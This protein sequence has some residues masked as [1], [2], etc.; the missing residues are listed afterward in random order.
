MFHSSKLVPHR[1]NFVTSC[2]IFC[3]LLMLSTAG[4]ASERIAS[5]SIGPVWPKDLL[6]SGRPTSW[7]AEGIYGIIV[8]RTVAFGLTSNFLWNTQSKEEKI[9]AT[10]RDSVIESHEYYMYPISGFIMFDPLYKRVIHPTFRLEIGYNSLKYYERESDV[11]AIDHP[12][13]YYFGLYTKLAIDGTYDI[14]KHSSFFVGG[15]YQWADT[16]T[17]ESNHTY[18]R[19]DMSGLG[20]QLGFRFLL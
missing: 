11:T 13:G 8:D 6:N 17:T 7:N 12:D 19:I 14:G 3:F 18:S 5:F 20:L 15:S 16:R 2:F 10:G 9:P 4:Y 1:L